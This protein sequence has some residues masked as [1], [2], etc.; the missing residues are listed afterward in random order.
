MK[1][2][3]YLYANQ[4][5]EFAINEYQRVLFLDPGNT[6]ATIYLY[7]SFFNNRQFNLALERFRKK[8][9][10]APLSNDTL[11]AIY[12]K[13]LLFAG[14]Y[15]ELQLGLAAGQD[16]LAKKD[17][18]IFHASSMLLQNKADELE[19]P[20]GKE[21]VYH[22]EIKEIILTARDIQPKKT[23][24]SLTSSAIIPGSGKI[25]SGFWKDG[26]MTL[27]FVSASAWQSYRG[28]SKNGIES[29]YGWVFG[30]LS[31]SFYAGNL[32][33]SIKATHKRNQVMYHEIHEQVYEYVESKYSY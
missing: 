9:P 3:D 20:R 12:N 22:P 6:R 21:K 15:E 13:I 4:Q 7:E 32:Y 33:G 27:L 24:I 16:C 8:I 23:W 18:Y 1:F 25:Y 5:Y 2:A 10:L 17:Q 29:V 19:Y 26:L 30:G 31:L 28:F 14:R 11:R